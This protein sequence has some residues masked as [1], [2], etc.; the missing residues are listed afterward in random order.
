LGEGSVFFF[1]VN[2]DAVAQSESELLIIPEKIKKLKTLVVDHR[3]SVRS[4]ITDHLLD[5]G[6]WVDDVDRARMAFEAV[7]GSIKTNEPYQ[8]LLINSR[9]PGIGGFRLAEKIR[10]ELEVKIP[11]VMIM[12]I[13]TRQGDLEQCNKIGMIDYIT[14]FINPKDLLEKITS[15]LDAKE[16][17]MKD[18]KVLNEPMVAKEDAL[19]ILL[20]EDS[21]DNRLLIQLYLKKSP[22]E[23]DIAENGEVALQMFDPDSYDL[24]LMDMQ[25]PVMDGY[26][27][28]QMIRKMEKTNNFRETP[29]IALTAHALKGDREKCLDAGCT[30]YMAKPIKKDKLLEI[31]QDYSRELANGK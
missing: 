19:R 10:N 6:L 31:L 15:T 2:F 7:K 18:E 25:M 1:T 8:L 12:P 22:H 24:V 30:D 13:D 26:T 16:L 29:I 4:M 14:K 3:P 5:W 27:A 9:L 23:V 21:A 28:T 20:V 17:P 11:T